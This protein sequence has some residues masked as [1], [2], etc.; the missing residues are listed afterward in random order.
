MLYARL[1]HRIEKRARLAR[2]V[3][4]IAQRIGNRIRHDDRA[5]EMNDGIDLPV[6]DHPGDEL[7]IGDIADDK[8]RF[9]CHGPVEAGRQPVENKNLLA[10]IEK[11]PH[12]VTADISGAPGDQYR[13]LLSLHRFRQARLPTP[14]LSENG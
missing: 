3:V 11:L 9:G 12:H 2:I 8:L 13:H 6:R 7:C 10:R 5:R 4:V 1:D 14:T